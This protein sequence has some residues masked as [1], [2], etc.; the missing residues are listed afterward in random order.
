V[1]GVGLVGDKSF[2]LEFKSACGA[3]VDFFS[4]ETPP[5]VIYTT[6]GTKE[7]EL[8]A[9]DLGTQA[10]SV[11]G[12]SIIV[13]NNSAPDIQFTSQNMCLGIDINFNAQNN[14]GDLAGYDWD[15]G[16]MSAPAVTSSTTHQ[17]GAPGNY[18]VTLLVTATN[19]CQNTASENLNVYNKPIASFTNAP[20]LLCT[21]NELT[22]ETATHDNFDGNLTYQWYIDD[23]PVSTDRDLLYT[24]TNTGVKS[25]KLQTSI[26]GCSDEVTQS[27]SDI[28]AG[29]IVDFSF[30]GHCEDD[31]V[32]FTSDIDET[33]VSYDW[34]FSNNPS[35]TDENPT[36]TFANAGTYSVTLTALSLSG[37]NNSKTK[38]V[39]IY[40]TPAV[41]FKI[42]PPPLSCSGS[43]TNFID[44]TIDPADSDIESWQW[45][46]G[47]PGSDNTSVLENPQHT[48]AN[49]GD[50]LV[51]L[52]ATTDEGCSE[53]WQETITITPSPQVTITNTPACLGVPVQF[54]AVGANVNSYYWEFGTLYYEIANPTHTFNTAGDKTIK[55]TITGDNNCIAIYNRNVTVPVALAPDFTASNY[56]TGTTAVFTDIT[57][58]VDPVAQRSWDFSGEGT[59]SE[60]SAS[61]EFASTG[62]KNI[63]L[64][65]VSEA[66]CSYIKNK[67]IT[68]VAP[69]VANFSASPESGAAPLQVQFTN[70]SVGATNYQWQFNDGAGSTSGQASPSFTFTEPGQ[71]GVELTASNPEGCTSTFIKEINTII[72]FP[73]VDL[74]MITVSEN[75]DGTLKVIITIHNKGNTILRDLPVVIDISGRLSLT[76]TIAGPIAPSSMYNLV[77]SYSLNPDD[78]LDFFCAR[79]TLENDLTPESNRICKEFE[80]GVFFFNAY[81]NP[82]VG[83]LTVDWIAPKE[84]VVTVSLTD[85]FGK[86]VLS[87]DIGSVEG[88]NSA[89]LELSTFKNGIYIL[90]IQGQSIQ[91]TQRIFVSAQN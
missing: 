73:D 61:F 81:P 8:R 26:P 7:I 38:S 70:T 43:V 37:C 29:P 71:F 13:S 52:T 48:F 19:G 28:Q 39:P 16:D 83:Y 21:N 35:S 10:F 41:D 56:C 62:S 32:Q 88:L 46:F 5:A 87:A 91:K 25:I 75:A 51:S 58:G 57:T 90:R 86:N 9:Q 4:G 33:V 67:T 64:N 66:G 84:Q 65:I 12:N 22:F 40:S 60:A 53:T 42:N 36:H 2:Q 50:Y 72:G 18:R 3:S 31:A 11:T 54:A 27:T 76:E 74:K 69:P 77:L 6:S 59:A 78:D 44:L 1:Q 17:Y 79:T 63:R 68:V 47:D 49:A 24:F 82:A 85:C 14:S 34:D 80:N 23:E 45:N 89:R 55:L 30:S 15:F 20:G